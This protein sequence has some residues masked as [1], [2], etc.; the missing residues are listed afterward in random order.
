MNNDIMTLPNFDDI[1]PMSNIT[2][3]AKSNQSGRNEDDDDIVMNQREREREQQQQAMASGRSRSSDNALMSR[4]RHQQQQQQQ[5]NP[6]MEEAYPLD[7]F[8]LQPP[9]LR[10]RELMRDV[11]QEAMNSQQH[12]QPLPHAQSLE[13]HSI[14][15]HHSVTFGHNGQYGRTSANGYPA[16][17]V[18]AHSD[19]SVRVSN[20]SRSYHP[21]ED[22][23]SARHRSYS[24]HPHRR[25]PIPLQ[26]NYPNEW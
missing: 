14:P 6:M 2:R 17:S 20:R 19:Q 13:G 25:L 18:R 12:Q 23:Q 4:R 16:T 21:R 22:H 10:R 1:D 15:S 5:H 26:T 7:E 9:P 24:S 3:L 11:D 8:Q